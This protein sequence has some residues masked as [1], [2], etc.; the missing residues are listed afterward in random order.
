MLARGYL[1]HDE[2][3][4]VLDG[5]PKDRIELARCVS[6]LGA[7]FPTLKKPPL[8]RSGS[9]K[10]TFGSIATSFPRLWTRMAAVGSTDTFTG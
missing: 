10:R 9:I 5:K 6:L 2:N 1:F 4:N 3:G 8:K 7:V